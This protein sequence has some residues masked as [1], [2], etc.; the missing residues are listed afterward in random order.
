MKKLNPTKKVEKKDKVEIVLSKPYLIEGTIVPTGTKVLVEADDIYDDYKTPANIADASQPETTDDIYTMRRIARL[1]KMDMEDM[2]EGEDEEISE[3]EALEQEE[4][5]AM[6]NLQRIRRLRRLQKMDMEED[7]D[8]MLPVADE[9]LAEPVVEPAIEP[10]ET[11]IGE[12]E[13]YDD[14]DLMTLRRI[15]RIRKLRQ[16]K[17]LR[18]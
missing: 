15:A 11:L 13:E 17:N 2:E 16:M 14:E 12:P 6:K 8:E 3:E 4:I 9:L 18:K 7:D 1:K 5:E 10:E